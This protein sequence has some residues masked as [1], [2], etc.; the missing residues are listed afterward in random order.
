MIHL[1]EQ[2]FHVKRKWRVDHVVTGPLGPVGLEYEG[3]YNGTSRH[4]TVTGFEEDALKYREATIG[5]LPILH[6]TTHHVGQVFSDLE[7]F[8]KLNTK[9]L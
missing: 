2:M 9:Q 1:Q 8:Y 3:I 5:G 6:Y 4:T 7:R